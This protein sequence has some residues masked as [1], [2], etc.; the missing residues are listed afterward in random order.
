[1]THALPRSKGLFILYIIIHSLAIVTA[2]ARSH[3]APSARTQV[4]FVGAGLFT[5]PL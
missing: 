1:M 4:R 2:R 3:P 5:G